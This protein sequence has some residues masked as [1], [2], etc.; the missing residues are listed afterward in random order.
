MADLVKLAKDLK[1]TLTTKQEPLNL[2]SHNIKSV[3]AKRRAWLLDGKEAK[4]SSSTLEAKKTNKKS[5]IKT[6]GKLVANGYQ[7]GSKQGAIKEQS[8]SKLV[9]ENT[10]KSVTGIKLVAKQGAK[11]GANREQTGSKPVAE[12]FITQSLKTLVGAQ[13][14]IIL[15]F[16]FLAKQTGTQ[17]TGKIT[18]DHIYNS[19]KIGSDVIRNAITRL[20]KKGHIFRSFGKVGRGGWTTYNLSNEIYKELMQQDNSGYIE[21]QTDSKLVAEQVA[22]LVAEQVAR[23][24]SSSSVINIK[25][26]TTDLGI[27]PSEE[28][29]VDWQTIDFSVL[30]DIGFNKTHLVQLYK[31]GTQD[32]KMVQD[33]IYHFAFD[34]KHNGKKSGIKGDVLNFFMGIISKRAYTAPT[35]YINPDVESMNAYIKTKEQEQKQ[36]EELELKTQDLE[37]NHWHET[38]S[39]EE[40]NELVSSDT[41]TAGIPKQLQQTLKMNQLKKHFKNFVWPDVKRK[42][43]TSTPNWKNT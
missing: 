29:S 33:S 14:K 15:F 2:D 41:K 6:G 17:S 32:P 36:K 25:T 38:L 8:R 31:A 13:Y 26:T 18:Q 5:I 21:R 24:L 34:L 39:D 35:N 11:Q 22:K 43:L 9:A 16:Y 30:A 10:G 19:L 7:T 4:L 23:P 20:Q 40:I 28:M 1:V 3:G 42:I 12:N 37:F 27:N